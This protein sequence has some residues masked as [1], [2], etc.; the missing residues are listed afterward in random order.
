MSAD[1]VELLGGLTVPADA[2]RLLFALEDRGFTL[3]PE[4]D[5]LR[6]TPTGDPKPTL[7]EAETQAIR[8]WKPHLIALLT[9][10]PPEHLIAWKQPA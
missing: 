10:Q 4:G 2:Y 7:T 1:Y 5:R 6:V 8:K 9:Y 3:K